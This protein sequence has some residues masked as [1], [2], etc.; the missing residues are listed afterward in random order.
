MNDENLK[1]GKDTQFRTK[2]EAARSGTKGGIASGKARRRKRSMQ[3]ATKMIL[4]MKPTDVETVKMLEDF[5]FSGDDLTNMNAVIVAMIEKAK[6][7]NVQAAQFLRDTIGESPN[8]RS[9]K[10][11]ARLRADM[12]EYKKDCDSGLSEEIEDISASER[13][14][15]GDEP[16]EEQVNTKKKERY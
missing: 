11:D 14:I 8:E 4:D 9:R 2:E 5:G 16:V 15:Y 1:N 6:T 3:A 13:F 10:E 12:F 7:G